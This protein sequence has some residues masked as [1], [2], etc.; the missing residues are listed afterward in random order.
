MVKRNRT[1]DT[2]KTVAVIGTYLPRRC[3]IATFTADLARA[4][5]NIAKNTNCWALA[6]NDQPQGYRYPS[7]VKFEINHDR[8]TDYRVAADFLNMSPVLTRIGYQRRLQ[9]GPKSLRG[10]PRAFPGAP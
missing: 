4:I 5:S 9:D 10:A 1:W 7:R 8:V 3:G 6:L 2:L